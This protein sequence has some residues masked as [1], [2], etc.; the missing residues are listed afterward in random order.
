MPLDSA[1]PGTEGRPLVLGIRPEHFSLAPDGIAAEV[2]VVEPTGSETLLALRA[3]GQD[4]T[5]VLRERVAER[6]GETIRL[7]PNLVHFFDAETGRRLRG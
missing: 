4:I 5:C 1:P 7:R 3:G 2:V 6:P